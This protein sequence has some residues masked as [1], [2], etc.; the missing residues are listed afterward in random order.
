[1]TAYL[2]GGKLSVDAKAVIGSERRNVY[3][4]LVGEPTQYKAI[5]RLNGARLE[6]Y[7]RRQGGGSSR[8]QGVMNGQLTL[9]GKGQDPKDML[10]EGSLT[11]KPAALYEL[12]LV[13]RIFQTLNITAPA[14]SVAFD[15][16]FLKFVIRNEQFEFSQISLLGN[17]FS[18]IGRGTVRFDE[19]VDLVFVSI[20]P[21]SQLM[22]PLVRE[23]VR[24]ASHGWVAVDVKGTI[25]DPKPKVKTNF[26]IDNALRNILDSFQPSRPLMEGN[27]PASESPQRLLPL[28]Q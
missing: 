10:G 2:L 28:R 17:G 5:L 12:P 27:R 3:G 24:S 18:L 6:E 11:I 13:L 16:A 26:V 19:K 7:L 25:N 14:D 15:E 23:I 1:M 21:K 4:Q 20:A 9:N 22:I 8:L